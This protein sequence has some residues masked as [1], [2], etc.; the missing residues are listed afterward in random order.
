MLD[1]PVGLIREGLLSHLEGQVQAG[2]GGVDGAA[3]VPV[4]IAIDVAGLVGELR[5]GAAHAAADVQHGLANV[6]AVSVADLVARD[7]AALYVD[8]HVVQRAV[9]ALAQQH[10]R[11]IALVRRATVR[12]DRHARLDLLG[13]AAVD[14]GLFEA[15]HGLAIGGLAGAGEDGPVAKRHAVVEGC[16]ARVGVRIA[17]SRVAVPGDR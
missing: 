2:V 11:Q 7:V 12:H 9:G 15:G 13:G 17:P 1:L 5:Q 6:V 3:A 4:R 8:G 10:D 14:D 16:R